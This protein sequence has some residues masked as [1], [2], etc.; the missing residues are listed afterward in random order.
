M[1]LDDFMLDLDDRFEFYANKLPVLNRA[2]IR[3]CLLKSSPNT[4]LDDVTQVI[5]KDPTLSARILSVVNSALFPQFNGITVVSRA[6]NLLGTDRAIALAVAAAINLASTCQSSLILTRINQVGQRLFT[7]ANGCKWLVYR[8]DIAQAETAALTALL[9]DLGSLF[10][11]RALDFSQISVTDDQISELLGQHSR[12]YTLKLFKYWGLPPL[13]IQVVSNLD[14]L[15]YTGQPL[16]AASLRFMQGFY[17][18]MLDT[19]TAD[20]LPLLGTDDSRTLSLDLSALGTLQ[21][22]LLESSYFSNL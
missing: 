19:S 1:K 11:L 12:H 6:V 22:Y 9:H 15:D 5:S 3:L 2:A 7:L 16:V 20:M 4:T 10:V 8:K 21:T 18:F 13:Y 14:N 17:A